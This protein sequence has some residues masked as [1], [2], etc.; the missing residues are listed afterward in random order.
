[1]EEKGEYLNFKV[2][3]KEDKVDEK[4]EMILNRVVGLPLQLTEIISYTKPKARKDLGEA[5]DYPMR[6]VK[7]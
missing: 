4:M 6:R 1:M 3:K 7:A 5:D 2:P